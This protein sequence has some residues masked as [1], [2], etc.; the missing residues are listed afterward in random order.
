MGPLTNQDESWDLIG[1]KSYCVL[2]GL[3]SRGCLP[4][5]ALPTKNFLSTIFKPVVTHSS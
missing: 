3:S 1:L 2:R 5:L 4:A